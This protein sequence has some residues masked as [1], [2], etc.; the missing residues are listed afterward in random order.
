[1]G[2]SALLIGAICVAGAVVA[3]VVVRHVT[4]VRKSTVSAA[5]LIPNNP[6][7]R[8]IL[9]A[10]EQLKIG[11]QVSYLTIRWSIVGVVHYDQGGSHWKEFRLHRDGEWAWLSVD[12]AVEPP[13]HLFKAGGGTSNQ[14][15][16][17]TI[18][19]NGVTFRFRER[20]T[21]RFRSEGD[22]D[23]ADSGTLEFVDYHIN[24]GRKVLSFERYGNG[25]W[26]VAKGEAVEL[27]YIS[28]ATVATDGT[29]WQ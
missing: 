21:A 14:P 16:A 27:P 23:M 11:H 29:G 15:G 28:I 17:D 7:P 25:S 26:E 2:T 1:M 4:G 9:A 12:A 13:I 6:T 18:T 19:D 22:T 5:P 10:L 3:F 20:G 8:Q 24:D